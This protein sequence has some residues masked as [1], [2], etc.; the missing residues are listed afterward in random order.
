MGIEPGWAALKLFEVATG[1]EVGLRYAYPTLRFGQWLD[2]DTFTAVGERRNTP[3]AKAD[4]LTCSTQS[5]ACEVAAPAFSTFT[6]SKTPPRTTPFAVPSG[7][8]I[9]DQFS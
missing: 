5:G 8:P 7:S 6:F 3:S 4:L 2:D 1:R 9:Y